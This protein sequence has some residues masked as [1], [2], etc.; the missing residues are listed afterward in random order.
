MTAALVAAGLGFGAAA[1]WADAPPP[2]A[3][4]LSQ[5]IAAVERQDDFA[6][7]KEIDW[8]DDGYYEVEYRTRGGGDREVKI[9]PV[10]G[11]V[12]PD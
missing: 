2:N 11:Q 9:D 8:D 5:L 6:H 12:R 10:T 3:R 7:F 1:A 4:P